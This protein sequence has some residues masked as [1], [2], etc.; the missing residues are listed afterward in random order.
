MFTHVKMSQGYQTD[1]FNLQI[2]HRLCK[3]GRGGN[4]IATCKII[5]YPQEGN[6]KN[7]DHLIAKLIEGTPNLK[8][9]DFIN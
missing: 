2:K 9:A 5:S 4:P 8:E 7:G 6:N 1:G 3:Q